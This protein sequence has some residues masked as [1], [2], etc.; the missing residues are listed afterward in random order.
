MLKARIRM[1]LQTAG[2]ILEAQI[3]RLLHGK[4]LHFP[5]LVFLK[6]VAD[7][8][9][10][11]VIKLSPTARGKRLRSSLG[12]GNVVSYVLPREWGLERILG[13]F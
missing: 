3:Y 8:G 12:T 1:K 6:R 5:S 10:I 13:I 2:F 11:G 7:N 4:L 9:V